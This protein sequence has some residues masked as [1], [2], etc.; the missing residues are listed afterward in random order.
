MNLEYQTLEKAKY[1][2]PDRSAWKRKSF[3][4]K[5]RR[6]EW[7]AEELLSLISKS[8]AFSACDQPTYTVDDRI[9]E[10]AESWHDDLRV[11]VRDMEWDGYEWTI[12]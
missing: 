10:A 12:I 9:I 6:H 2:K 7:W 1:R 3:F 11:D 8:K 4:G 5:T